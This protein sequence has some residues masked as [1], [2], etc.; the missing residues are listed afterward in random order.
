[1]PKVRKVPTRMCVACKQMKP[2]RELIRVVRVADGGVR[3]DPT[4]KIAGRGAYVCPTEQCAEAGVRE[5]R[6]QHALEVP[7]PE[8]V[9]DEL[10]RVIAGTIAPQAADSQ[11]K[12]IRIPASAGLHRRLGAR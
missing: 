6:L 9:H 5:G 1:M 12:V 4:S 10:R 11:P 2:K 3:V 7:I 8:E